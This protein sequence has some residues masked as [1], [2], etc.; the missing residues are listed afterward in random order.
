MRKLS[1]VLAFIALIHL[2]YAQKASV[3]GTVE[4]MKENV[5]K[6]TLNFTMPQSTSSDEI[7]RTS[8]YYVDYF[9]VDYNESTKNAKISMIDNSP[10]G[11]RVVTRFLLSNKVSVIVFNENE[12]KITEFY[13]NFLKN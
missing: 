11:R 9:T 7:N 2:G 3:S 8:Q 10:E 4:T 1:I 5:S 6:G 13:D 12:Y